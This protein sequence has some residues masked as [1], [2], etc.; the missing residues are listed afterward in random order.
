MNTV[1]KTIEAVLEVALL[2]LAPVMMLAF[3]NHLTAEITGWGTRLP[4]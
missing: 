1:R 4:F 3:W 2:I